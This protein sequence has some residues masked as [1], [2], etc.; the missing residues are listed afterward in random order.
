MEWNG[1]CMATYM[2]YGYMTTDLAHRSLFVQ[3]EGLQVV[4]VVGVIPV[5]DTVHT[6][7][8]HQ[9]VPPCELR[10]RFNEQGRVDRVLRG[11][12]LASSSHLTIF[13]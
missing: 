13:F 9:L 8:T 3:R 12:G 6:V 10:L 2:C 1:I 7:A 5:H 11:G 4:E